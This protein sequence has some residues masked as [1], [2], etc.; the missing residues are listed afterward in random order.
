MNSCQKF[1]EPKVSSVCW[2][3]IGKSPNAVFLF[4]VKGHIKAADLHIS[5]SVTSKCVS[6]LVALI[7]T[8]C[9]PQRWWKVQV[10]RCSFIS[11]SYTDMRCSILSRWYRVTSPTRSCKCPGASSQPSWPLPATWMPS[12]AHM[13]ITSTEPSSGEGWNCI[14][15]Y[16]SIYCIRMPAVLSVLKIGY[17]WFSLIVF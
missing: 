17:I 9:F 5:K 15:A 13:Q 7:M 4:S 8:V 12:T 1:P 3:T 11:C 14:G 16:N 2:G 6:I 10:V